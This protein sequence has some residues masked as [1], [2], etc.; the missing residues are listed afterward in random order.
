MQT[1]NNNYIMIPFD[2]NGKNVLHKEEMHAELGKRA[3]KMYCDIL[4][5]VELYNDY[6]KSDKTDRL[7]LNDN[8]TFSVRLGNFEMKAT[9][10]AVHTE[11]TQGKMWGCDCTQITSYLFVELDNKVFVPFKAIF[12]DWQMMSKMRDWVSERCKYDKMGQKQ[13]IEADVA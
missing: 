6:Y 7:I 4:Y 12:K 11:T 1:K 8:D 5:Y 3:N 10:L 2:I 9:S 13:F